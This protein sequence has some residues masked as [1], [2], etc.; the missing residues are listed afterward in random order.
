M[1]GPR[2]A[3]R[4]RQAL[5]H[6]PRHRACPR[7]AR[8]S[9]PASP[10]NAPDPLD[11]SSAPDATGLATLEAR[12][13]QDPAVAGPAGAAPGAAPGARRPARAAG[14]RHRRRHGRAHA[15]RRRSPTWASRRPSSTARPRAW[16]ARWLTTARM[17]TLRSP[18]ELHR[19][20]AGPARA[21]LPCLAR[22]A[23]RRGLAG[24]GQDPAPAVGAVPAVVPPRACAARAQPARG[25]GRAPAGRRRGAPER[26]GPQRPWR[27]PGF[28]RARAPRGAGQ[29]PR[30]A[31]R[32]P[33]AALG[34]ADIPR[35][36]WVHSAEHWEV[37]ALCRPARGGDPA[38]APRPWTW[39][40]PRWK[41]AP[42]AWTCS[43]AAPCCRA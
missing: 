39:L 20:G 3:G 27:H 17:E 30:R 38:A 11:V 37:R 33:G 19:P 22:G 8:G 9:P 21:H 26:G 10:M 28:Q 24:A 40:P 34:A 18:K 32:P 31:G 23:V 14:G 29:R 42:R 13:R 25:A 36:R 15:G 1:R 4:A 41:P 43:S 16:R 7:P 2:H 12:L 6:D 35:A 5:C